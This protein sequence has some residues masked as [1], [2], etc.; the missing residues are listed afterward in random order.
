MR[1]LSRIVVT[2]ALVLGSV[3]VVAQQDQTPVLDAFFNDIITAAQKAQRALHPTITDRLVRPKPPTP[4][5]GPAGFTFRDSTFG[6]RLV[7]VTDANTRSDVAGLSFRTPAASPQRAW[8]SAS[9]RYYV[10]S[11]DGSYWSYRWDGTTATRDPDQIPLSGDVSFSRTN[12]TLV[13]GRSRTLGQVRDRRAISSYDLV[14]KQETLVLDPDVLIPGLAAEGDTYSAN[15]FSTD[16]SI[17]MSFG[18]T[19]ND[20]THFVVSLPLAGGRRRSSIR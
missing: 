1:R 14:T 20:Y 3:T 12:P 15:V 5:L 18:G 2:L 9:D 4:I 19:G 6:S 13:Y 11:T 16:T 8:N 7:R 10:T 17:V